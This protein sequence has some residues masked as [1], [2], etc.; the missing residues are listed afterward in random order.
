M[1]SKRQIV[2]NANVYFI[3]LLVERDDSIDAGSAQS[4]CLTAKWN[5]NK[6]QQVQT[7]KHSLLFVTDNELLVA[8]YKQTVC[9]N[10]TYQYIIGWASGARLTQINLNMSL[11]VMSYNIFE[12][13]LSPN[14]DKALSKPI[15]NIFPVKHKTKGKYK[16]SV[17]Y[18]GCNV[19]SYKDKKGSRTFGCFCLENAR[20]WNISHITGRCYN[21]CSFRGVT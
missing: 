18:Y 9:N 16:A 6:L 7:N 2:C 17:W 1:G 4:E 15:T 8:L 12:T 10:T 19:L 5:T 14:S 20:T 13:I 21:L 3:L 11:K